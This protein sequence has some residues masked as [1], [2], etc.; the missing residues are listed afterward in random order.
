MGQ[1][2]QDIIGFQA[3]EGEALAKI[4]I[5][6]QGLFDSGREEVPELPS[7]RS[8]YDNLGQSQAA[9]LGEWQLEV[10][11]ISQTPGQWAAVGV[12]DFC[13]CLK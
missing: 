12:G 1:V 7:L 11:V 13:G 3:F 10:G 8:G 2:G 9:R 4:E 6:R 5:G